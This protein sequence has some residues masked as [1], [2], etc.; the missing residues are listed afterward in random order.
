MINTAYANFNQ[1]DWTSQ[2][3]EA[4]ATNSPAW[5]SGGNGRWGCINRNRTPNPI[6][7]PQI[8]AA[9]R[10]VKVKGPCDDGD[11]KR[12]ILLPNSGNTAFDDGGGRAAPC[13]EV[14]GKKP[15]AEYVS[16]AGKPAVL[17]CTYS[18]LQS[19]DLWDLSENDR[20]IRKI[21]NQ[22]GRTDPVSIWDQLAE[23]WCSQSIDR[24]GAVISANNNET[25]SNLFEGAQRDE[26]ILKYC[27]RNSNKRECAC[28]NTQ[29]LA[30][31]NG[32]QRCKDTPTKPGCVE[33]LEQYNNAPEELQ[34]LVRDGY[35]R[36]DCVDA[37]TCSDP[38]VYKP[39]SFKPCEVNLQMCVQE[40]NIT[41][42]NQAGKIAQQ[43]NLSMGGPT[44]APVDVP[45]PT[46]N[47][48]PTASS[49]AGADAGADA[50]ADGDDDNTKLYVA[51]GATAAVISSSFMA[52]LLIA[53]AG[54]K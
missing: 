6:P 12:P 41:D 22:P 21:F 7:L 20:A 36:S 14:N 1:S 26:E 54:S 28:M 16:Y 45:T 43:C 51:G 8:W 19:N 32:Y 39:S 23:G 5:D 17:K 33:L 46:D 27:A 53:V 50:D 38:A 15:F 34:K 40:Q 13:P 35:F 37:T 52:L 49:G 48:Q 4:A 10:S 30:G 3:F 9:G 18:D 24:F 42:V 31:K 25:C 47:N 2:Q 29:T 44:A 11:R